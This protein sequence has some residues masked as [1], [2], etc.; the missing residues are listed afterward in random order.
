MELFSPT[1][2]KE[3]QKNYSPGK[4]EL[5]NCDM[6]KLLI[7]SPKKKK[8][9]YISGTEIL[10]TL[11][12][13]QEITFRTRKISHKKLLIFEEGL[14]KLEIKNFLVVYGTV[15][16]QLTINTIEQKDMPFYQRDLL[17]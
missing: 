13:L 6:K 2:K 1:S 7:F 4:M 15:I 14:P 12:I 17:L 9:Y 16:F 5:C 3:R 10:K 8:R 11:D